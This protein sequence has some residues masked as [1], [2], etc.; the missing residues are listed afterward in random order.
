MMMRVIGSKGGEASHHRQTLSRVSYGNTFF[1][2]C[3]RSLI[4]NGHKNNL[5]SSFIPQREMSV[6][7]LISSH[8]H[9]AIL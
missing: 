2:Y 7:G 5:F 9:K 6:R 8:V 1:A 4:V 3:V